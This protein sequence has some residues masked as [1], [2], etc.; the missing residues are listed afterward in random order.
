[1]K[2]KLTK[3]YEIAPGCIKPV[4]FELNGIDKEKYQWLLDNGYLTVKKKRRGK[5]E[6]KIDK[7]NIETKINK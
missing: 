1:M 2:A 3:P 6:N 5:I 7:F 4:G